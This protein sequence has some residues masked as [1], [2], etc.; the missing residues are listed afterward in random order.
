MCELLI[1]SVKSV[2]SPVERQNPV[3]NVKSSSFKRVVQIF[4]AF[5]NTKTAAAVVAAV[6]AIFTK[7][8]VSIKSKPLRNLCWYYRISR[9]LHEILH[10]Y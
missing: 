5:C 1:P 8:N 4:C 9:S 2:G 3:T 10:N 7:A 6:V